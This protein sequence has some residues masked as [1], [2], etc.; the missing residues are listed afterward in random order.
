[1]NRSALSLVSPPKLT[2]TPSAEVS[3]K[4]P[5]WDK[6]GE[7]ERDWKERKGGGRRTRRKKQSARGKK[8]G[9]KLMRS[10]LIIELFSYAPTVR[11]LSCSIL[12]AADIILAG[13]TSHLVSPY[14]SVKSSVELG[15]SRLPLRP[16][17]YE[18]RRSSCCPRVEFCMPEESGDAL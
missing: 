10:Q 11:P 14:R 7:R 8:N 5:P 16:Y 9:T 6:K 15:I 2:S 1:M 13:C 3:W 17:L 18:A 12:P 4:N